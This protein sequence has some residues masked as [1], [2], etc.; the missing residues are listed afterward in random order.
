MH[1]DTQIQKNYDERQK[2]EADFKKKKK[3]IVYPIYSKG[4]T[5]RNDR[6]PCG[7]NLKFKRCCLKGTK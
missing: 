7:S 3:E 2:A 5:G 1:E 6:C 4:K